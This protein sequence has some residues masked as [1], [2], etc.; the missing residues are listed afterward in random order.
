[1]DSFLKKSVVDHLITIAADE[2]D[3]DLRSRVVISTS[4]ERA[5]IRMNI[6]DITGG[7]FPIVVSEFVAEYPGVAG[8]D[9]IANLFA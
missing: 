9:A 5:V 6:N 8:D 3:T 2:P 7:G 4:Y 1:L